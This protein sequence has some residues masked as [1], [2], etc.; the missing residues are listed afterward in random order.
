MSEKQIVFLKKEKRKIIYINIIR[1]SIAFLF[2][3][4]WEIL[5]KFNILN[6]FITSSPTK[7]IHTI[8]SLINDKNLFNHIF[9]TTKETLIAFFIAS[10]LSIIVSIIFFLFN[11]LAKIFDPYLTM[12]NS[13]P[14]IALGP[15]LIIIIGAN[16]NSIIVMGILI[17]IIISIQNIY[18]GFINTDKNKIKLFQ[19]FKAS[20]LQILTKVVF[21][22]N[23]K[24]IINTLK[25]NISMALIGV[26]MGEFLT[27]KAGIG[28]LILYGSQIFNLDLVVSGIIILI[29]LS[30]IMYYLII[31]LEKKLVKND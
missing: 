4:F 30:V 19:T 15:M 25:I 11:T 17:S 12:L 7:V 21:P 8:T 26:I 20:R 27:S 16:T 28:Y 14:K 2:L 6:S 18:N 13:L 24:T 31:I 10:F 29:I 22:S 23:Y 3:F 5:T 9:I 1:I